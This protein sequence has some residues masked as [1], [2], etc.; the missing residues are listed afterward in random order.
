M[1]NDDLMVRAKAAIN[2][3]LSDTSVSQGTTRELLEELRAEIDVM[4]DSLT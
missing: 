4:L 2:A 1:S 3:V